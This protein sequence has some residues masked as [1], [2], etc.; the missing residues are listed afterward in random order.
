[1]NSN[2]EKLRVRICG[3]YRIWSRETGKSYIGQSQDISKRWA[4]HMSR[5]IVSAQPQHWC[6]EILEQCDRT[7][8]SS[9]EKH[10][11]SQ[12]DSIHPNGYNKN[13]APKVAM[14][15][16]LL[17]MM[18]DKSE[19]SSVKKMHLKNVWESSR[20]CKDSERAP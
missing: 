5:G 13:N 15:D 20:L 3:I 4:E 9:R 14:I 18:Q 16:E 11:I 7:K 17:S 8:L 12:F 2:H 10:W 19:I 1:M 6:F